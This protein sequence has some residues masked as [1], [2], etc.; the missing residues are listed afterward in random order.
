MKKKK[1]ELFEE[2]EVLGQDDEDKALKWVQEIGKRDE[3]QAK[4]SES[5]SLNKLDLKKNSPSYS[6][7][8]VEEAQ[9]FMDNFD[10]PP[11]FSW[12]SIKTIKGI[13]FWYR[14][15]NGKVFSRGNT[16]S[17]VPEIDMNGVVR[18]V[19]MMLDEIEGVE[20]NGIL[21]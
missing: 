5:D 11:G 6:Q 18:K 13:A 9:S 3:R 7:I 8:L 17:L 15:S 21:L 1:K 4:Q 12:G 16:I 19:F 20:K 14:D 2:I 10:L